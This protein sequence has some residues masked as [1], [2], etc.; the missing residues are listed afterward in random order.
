[1]LLSVN[2]DFTSFIILFYHN[3]TN[4]KI[5]EEKVL[6]FW[7]WSKYLRISIEDITFPFVKELFPFFIFHFSLYFFIFSFHFR[8]NFSKS[9]PSILFSVISLF[10]S[11]LFILFPFFLFPFSS[12]R[13]L[14]AIFVHVSSI[15]YLYLYL[16]L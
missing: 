11:F 6:K 5:C 10:F 12:L 8:S 2:N 16:S 7:N 3:L 13:F 4:L 1:M 9:F 15:F 14:S